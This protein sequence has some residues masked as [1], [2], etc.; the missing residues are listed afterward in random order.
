MK[1]V[2]KQGVCR[3]QC[4]LHADMIV[5]AIGVLLWPSL[6]RYS[7]SIVVDRHCAF[8][9]DRRIMSSGAAVWKYYTRLLSCCFFDYACLHVFLMHQAMF[10]SVQMPSVLTPCA[11]RHCTAGQVSWTQSEH[12]RNEIAPPYW[13]CQLPY[14]F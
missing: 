11:A 2:K 4:S 5:G 1:S 7:E 6:M 13:C 3:H 10:V 12:H 9:P 14:D 8:L